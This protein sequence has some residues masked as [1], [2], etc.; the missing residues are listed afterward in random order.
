MLSRLPIY[1]VRCLLLTQAAET[2]LAALL[3]FRKRDLIFVLLV[4]LLTNP[5]VVVLTF[6]CGVYWGRSVW[7]ISVILFE[8]AAFLTEALIYR[9]NLEKRKPNPFLVSLILNAA[10]YAA[11]EVV[12]IFFK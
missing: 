5:P 4:N 2:G 9:S 3:G 8:A 12:N 7:I 6:L 11:G 10:S 1:M